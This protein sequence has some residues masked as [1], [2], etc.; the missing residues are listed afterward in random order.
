M[1]HFALIYLNYLKMI[2]MKAFSNLKIL[3]YLKNPQHFIKKMIS[4]FSVINLFKENEEI[5]IFPSFIFFLLKLFVKKMFISTFNSLKYLFYYIWKNI[6]RRF[7]SNL[8]FIIYFN[9]FKEIN[10]FFM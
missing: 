10:I 2:K 4:Y 8:Q 7:N 5:Y 9:F 1:I 3:I 6:T